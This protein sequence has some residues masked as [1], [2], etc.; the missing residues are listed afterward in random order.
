MTTR[1][2]SLPTD[3]DDY[4]EAKVASGEYAHFSE[5]FRDGIRLLMQRDAEKLEWLR[6]AVAEG[7]ASADRDE[8]T[9]IEDVIEELAVRRKQRR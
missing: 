7:I 2:V 4:V 1:N 8:L 3:L 6:A 9:P 5:V